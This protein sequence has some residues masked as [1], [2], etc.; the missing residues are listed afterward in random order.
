MNVER[1]LDKVFNIIKLSPQ[2]TDDDHTRLPL[3]PY[4]F[5]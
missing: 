2:A 5:A 4:K 1:Q 3:A